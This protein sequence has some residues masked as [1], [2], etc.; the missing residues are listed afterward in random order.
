MTRE[1]SDGEFRSSIG[2]RM[3]V[4]RRPRSLSLVVLSREA[5]VGDGEEMYCRMEDGG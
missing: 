3:A 4:M 1:M 5:G 2:G